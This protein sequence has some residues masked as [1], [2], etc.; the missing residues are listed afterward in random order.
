[1]VSE[2]KIRQLAYAIWEQEGRPEGKA[3][4]HY[5]RARQILEQDELSN[6]IELPSPPRSKELPAPRP[7]AEEPPKKSTR[8]SAAKKKE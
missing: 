5:F 8:R 6:V 2:E 7:G 4:E 3:M 1:M